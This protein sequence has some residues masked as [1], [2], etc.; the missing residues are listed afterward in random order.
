MSQTLSHQK[1]GAWPTNCTP[2]DAHASVFFSI[3][4]ALHTQ[5]TFALVLNFEVGHFARHFFLFSFFFPFGVAMKGIHSTQLRCHISFLS[6]V[7]AHHLFLFCFFSS[8]EQLLDS[9]KCRLFR[10]HIQQPLVV[11]LNDEPWLVHRRQQFA[12]SAFQF[13]YILLIFF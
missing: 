1:R 11:S 4:P 9:R 12:S 3:L 6:F 13:H 8:R 2:K 5:D 7:P 10:L